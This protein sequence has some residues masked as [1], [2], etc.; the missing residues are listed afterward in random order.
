MM[1][2][3]LYKPQYTNINVAN[4][5]FADYLNFAK[6]VGILQEESELEDW[7][8]KVLRKK[9]KL[10]ILTEIQNR[11][12]REN[13]NCIIFVMGK[14]GSGKSY[15]CLKIAELFDPTFKENKQNRIIYGKN[16]FFFRL[17][18]YQYPLKKGNA[19][20]FEELGT[21]LDSRTWYDFAQRM[22]NYV[23]Q[24]FRYR[25]LLLI[26]NAPRLKEI[27]TRVLG[28]L[29]IIIDV[30][31]V[32][33]TKAFWINKNLWRAYMIEENQIK[34]LLYGS[35][36]Y[37]FKKFKNTDGSDIDNFITTAPSKELVDFYEAISR[38]RKLEMNY[39]MFKDVSERYLLEE[40]QKGKLDAVLKEIEA[41]IN[42][43]VKKRGDKLVL[44]DEI[45]RR[46]FN[47]NSN[48]LKYIKQ[49]FDLKVKEKAN[50]E[51]YEEKRIVINDK[52]RKNT[53]DIDELLDSILS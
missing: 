6:E 8:K 29:D 33:R 39:S 1:K 34:S 42:E 52:P 2:V 38:E 22:F 13:R 48:D 36:H 46:K 53:E 17:L 47:L 26:L 5:S 18:D 51:Q 24:T 20:I 19:I 9:F 50:I 40:G 7:Q 10:P 45:V 35:P 31:P 49:M 16:T 23:I 3:E 32:D 41:N 4:L 27:D 11:I 30:K 12:Y 15:V 25:N 44:L 43:Y 28:Y 21:E 37:Y 14:P